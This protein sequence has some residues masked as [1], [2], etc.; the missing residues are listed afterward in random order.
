M[1]S[2][3][4]LTL[5]L[6]THARASGAVLYWKLKALL[7]LSLPMQLGVLEDD[8]L[9]QSTIPEAADMSMAIVYAI[10]GV[11][12]VLGNSMLL[13]V[14]Y[15]KKHLL[16]P[17][18]FFIINLAVSD[19]GLTVSLYPMAIMSSVFHRWLFGKTACLIYAFCGLLFG[20]CSLTT[21]TLLS[22]VCFM[23]VCY[24]LYGNRFRPIH[25]RLLVAC[26]WLYALGFAGCPLAHWGEYGPEPYGTACCIDLRLSNLQAAAR[27]YT[28]ALFVGCYLLPC[29]IIVVSYVS[30]LVTVCTTKRAIERHV[31]KVTR[32][33][34]IQAIIV[35]LS[36]A[37]CIGFFTAWSP[38]AVVSMW[39]AFGHLDSIPPLAF[40]LPAMFAKSSTIYNPLV[41]M[42]L[43]PTFRKVMCRDLRRACL[44][45]CVCSVRPPAAAGHSKPVPEVAIV[46]LRRTRRRDTLVRS[47][48]HAE[49]A[50]P[51]ERACSACRDAY[52]CFRHYPRSC[53]AHLNPTA[54][55]VSC[56]A[57]DKCATGPSDSEMQKKR[58]HCIRGVLRERTQ[59]INNLQFNLEA[60][61]GHVK[62]A[63]P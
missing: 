58:L 34:N 50:L 37:V 24:P 31:P 55:C 38:Y 29:A 42:L 27:S 19:L 47:S 1:C 36:V 33:S 46:P 26:A 22:M 39:A 43:R 2:T 4:A 28:L 21:L 3:P 41:Y 62:V 5:S 8:V 12:S 30:I 48:V 17:A 16:K 49:L 18:E 52:E 32:I 54:A 59:D 15:K 60:V 23:K 9:F 51:R 40:A 14:S 20:I 25:G 6:A 57:K 53:C 45:G 13:Y 61:P 63:W 7:P 44:R 10:F 56:P 35:K 11:C